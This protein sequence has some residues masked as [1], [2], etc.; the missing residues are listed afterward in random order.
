MN[1]KKYVS[2]IMAVGLVASLAIAG[3]A[4]A[5]TAPQGG[6]SGGAGGMHRGGGTPGVFGTVSAVNG[7]TLTVTAKARP[8]M[9][10][11]ATAAPATP[12]TVYTVDASNAKVYKGSSTSTV[13]VSNI[14]MGDT[15]M[16]AGTVSGSNITATVIRDGIGGAMG[17]PGMS[18]GKGFG[19]GAS[20]TTPRAMPT[21]AIQGNG[22]PV[23]GGAVTAIDGST[24]TVTNAS[25]VTY[26]INAASSTI[27]KNGTSTTVASVAVGDNLIVQGTVSGT[28]VTASSVIDQGVKNGNTSSS[29][30]SASGSHGAGFG[31]GGIF[32]AIGGFF[33][34]LFGF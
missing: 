6:W 25:N 21:A 32:S 15:V 23:I 3:S 4:F 27:I 34:H 31:F 24:L 1:N 2:W 7:T 20:S 10:N 5:A 22:E 9:A 14:V 11:G 33:K 12:A 18:G 30:A 13:S 8:S 16:V 28:S 17:Q 19:R 26:T 29:G